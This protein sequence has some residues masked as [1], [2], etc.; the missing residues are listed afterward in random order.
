M[1]EIPNIGSF[2]ELLYYQKNRLGTVHLNHIYSTDFPIFDSP[3]LLRAELDFLP[4]S[5][6][7]LLQTDTHS[8]DGPD[9]LTIY[10]ER[11]GPDVLSYA[12]WMRSHLAHHRF[13]E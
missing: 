13:V 7:A 2:L 10:A 12:C 8:F 6:R 11:R 1:A 9:G 3:T 4:T 5:Y